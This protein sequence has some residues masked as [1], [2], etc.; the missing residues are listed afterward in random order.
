M[1]S[2]PFAS[3]ASYTGIMCGSSTAAAERDS[4]MKRCRNSSS[5]ASAGERILSATCRGSRSSWARNTTAVPPWPICSSRRYPAIREPG[6]KSVKNLTAPGLFIA[7]RGPSDGHRNSRQA[8]LMKPDRSRPC[9]IPSRLPAPEPGTGLRRPRLRLPK[10]ARWHKNPVEY[11]G[12]IMAAAGSSR[13]AGRGGSARRAGYGGDALEGAEAVG[14]VVDHGGDH[15]LVGL[16]GVDE[17][18]DAAL[19]GL[20]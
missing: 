3:P 8:V 2:T 15:Q 18:G 12:S 19:D 17:V 6:E 14:G 9:A 13:L 4:H 1:N 16:G 7:H 5:A 10:L 11:A 20:G